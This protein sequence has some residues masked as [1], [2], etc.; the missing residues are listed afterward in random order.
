MFTVYNHRA[1]FTSDSGAT[2]I[3]LRS[4]D[5]SIL[6]NYTPYP[7]SSAKPGFEI[8]NSSYI[9]PIATGLLHI[10]HTNLSL[11]NYVFNDADLSG[12]LFGL[13]PLVNLG[14]TAT[15]S[16]DS[17]SISNEHQQTVIYG[18]KSPSANVWRFS[19]PHHRPQS[20]RI[21]VRHEQD[22]ELVLYATASL[23]FPT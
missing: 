17:L 11:T 15:Y 13:A 8:A 20:A 5:S 21:V 6:S 18:T 9:Y 23:G 12:N 1:H 3:L 14:Y 2:D 16:R 22:V 10:P 4:S 19:L 7:D